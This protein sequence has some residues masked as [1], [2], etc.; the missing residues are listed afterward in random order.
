MA[1][2]VPAVMQVPRSAGHLDAVRI[3]QDLCAFL[4]AIN[5]YSSETQQTFTEQFIV[6]L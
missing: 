2:R 6:C 1:V 5:V 3:G 4:L